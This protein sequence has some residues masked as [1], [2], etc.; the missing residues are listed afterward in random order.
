MAHRG[1]DEQMNAL[2]A[3][4]GQPMDAA[5]EA[6]IRKALQGK[7]NF[8]AARAARLAEDGQLEALVPE[9]IAAFHR[10]FEDAAKSDPQCWAKNA[11]SRALPRLGCRDKEVFLRGLTFHQ[12]EPTWGGK[13]DTAGTLRANCAHALV[14]CEGLP[15]DE[16]LLLLVDL[17]VDADTSVRVEVARA[18]AQIGELAM[19]VLRLRALI[20]GEEPDVLAACFSALLSIDRDAGVPFVVRFLAAGD[21]AAGE[22]AFALAETHSAAALTALIDAYKTITHP[23]P[24]F[25]GALLSAIALTRLSDGADYLIGM[26]ERDEREATLAIE[27]LSKSSP[28]DELR[29]RIAKVVEDGGSP[30]LRKAL[31]DCG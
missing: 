6:L 28:N 2:D 26:I 16:L 31:K 20:P 12:W 5:A 17:L 13:S 14:A 3:L 11:L 18:M 15:S 29:A 25:T 8:L 19:P 1:F 30:R 23:E 22:A 9:L 27:A 4:K 24:W 10:F 21:D 7:S